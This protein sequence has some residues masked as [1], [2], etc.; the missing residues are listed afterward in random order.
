MTVLN[1]DFYAVGAGNSGVVKQFG[2]D[3]ALIR[4][5]NAFPGFAGG[6]HVATG[7]VNGDGVPDIV[8]GAGPGGGPHVQVFDGATGNLLR[9]FYAYA[10]SFAGGVNVAVGDFDSDG[11]AEIVT[12]AG[13]GGAPHVKV[14]DGATLSELRS[15]YAYDSSAVGGVSV[16]VGDVTGDGTADIV[17]GAGAG[18]GP[19]VKVF[20]G[21]AET[22]VSILL[23]LRI[24]FHRE[25]NVAVGNVVG[26]GRMD[27]IAGPGVGG[28]PRIRVFDGHDLSSVTNLLTFDE[29]FR[30]GIRVGAVDQDGDGLS[31]L[32]IG[33]GPGGTPRVQVLEPVTL[34]V[35]DDFLAFDA[36]NGFG[37]WVG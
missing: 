25:V 29:S 20:D 4:E 17:T 37:V 3:G 15:F 10:P 14:F 31:E 35:L 34:N 6:V 1:V 8:A 27:I 11:K 12:G 21:T 28:G 13:V 7:D 23:R 22:E 26:D 5:I 33:S 19:H 36:A 16:A 30:G 18:G 24:H 9:S 32:L 2:L